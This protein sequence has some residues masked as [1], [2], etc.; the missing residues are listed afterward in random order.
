RQD[1]RIRQD[2]I[3][4]L[5]KYLRYRYELSERALTHHAKVAADAMIGKVLQMWTDYLVVTE[6]LAEVPALRDGDLSDVKH[7]REDAA[8]TL[9]SDGVVAAEARALAK[10]ETALLTHGD[11]GFLEWLLAESEAASR[12]DPR[13]RRI[14]GV[15]ELAKALQNRRLF[16]LVG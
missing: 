8:N 11:D 4:E 9:G 5:L 2:T 15:A 1:G 13:D 10:I 12:A 14:A 6:L 3:T 16:K 7:V